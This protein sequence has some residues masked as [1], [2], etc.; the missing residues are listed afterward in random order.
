LSARFPLAPRVLDLAGKVIQKIADS[1][2]TAIGGK[3]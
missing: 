1:A 2:V 3:P